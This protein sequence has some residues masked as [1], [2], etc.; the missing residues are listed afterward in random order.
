M[1]VAFPCCEIRRHK[2]IT[3]WQKGLIGFDRSKRQDEEEIAEFAGISHSKWNAFSAVERNTVE[4]ELAFGLQSKD[5][6]HW[7]RSPMYVTSNA[8]GPICNKSPTADQH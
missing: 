6:T 3:D 5:T 4:M 2:Y 1:I 7:S 8:H